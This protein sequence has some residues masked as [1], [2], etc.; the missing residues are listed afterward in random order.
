LKK[1]LAKFVNFENRNIELKEK[2]NLEMLT[3]RYF[4]KY[5]ERVQ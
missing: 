1:I 5:R 3:R 4:E 2:L